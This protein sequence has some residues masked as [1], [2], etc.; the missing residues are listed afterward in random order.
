MK[1]DTAYLIADMAILQSFICRGV[2]KGWITRPKKKKDR[3][4]YKQ[5]KRIIK[6]E[7]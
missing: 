3:K 2:E 1:D 5:A 4:I 7:N 6:A